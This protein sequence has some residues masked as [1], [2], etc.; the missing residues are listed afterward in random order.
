MGVGGQRDAPTALS[1]GKRPATHCIG[2]WVGP[3]AGLYGY[4]NSRPPTGVR[5]PDRSA[6][7]ESLYRL[8][9]PDPYISP[10]NETHFFFQ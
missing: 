5:S 8:S 3:S 1:P 10:Y 7:S 4:R 6:R 2:D 9:Y